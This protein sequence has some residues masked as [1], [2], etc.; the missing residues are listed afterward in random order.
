MCVCVA[1]LT[2]HL[3]GQWSDRWCVYWS[4][5]DPANGKFKARV[6][7]CP[8]QVDGNG[9]SAAGAASAV[10]EDIGV[11]RVFF[12]DVHRTAEE[13]AAPRRY[14]PLV[15]MPPP[16]HTHLPIVSL[17]RSLTLSPTPWVTL[18][19]T[20][21]ATATVQEGKKWYMA[22]QNTRCV[23][24]FIRALARAY[25][26]FSVKH[27]YRASHP[28]LIVLDWTNFIFQIFWREEGSKTRVQV[29]DNGSVNP[30]RRG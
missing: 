30:S 29:P 13:A 11:I 18:R 5:S 20:P 12:F 15:P 2:L 16:Q 21:P 10:S 23:S 24:V 25:T 27:H 19:Y 9:A 7:G 22:S 1:R 4:G 26:R 17:T 6:F 8:E 3:V 14:V 28:L